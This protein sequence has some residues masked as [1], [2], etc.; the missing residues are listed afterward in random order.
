MSSDDPLPAFLR[1][2]EESESDFQAP[3]SVISPHAW[4]TD[5]AMGGTQRTDL[6]VPTGHRLAEVVPVHLQAIDTMVVMSAPLF[7]TGDLPRRRSTQLDEFAM[8]LNSNLVGGSVCRQNEV[9]MLKREEYIADAAAAADIELRLKNFTELHEATME[10]LELWSRAH[11]LEGAI[12][13]QPIHTGIENAETAE[14]PMMGIVW[15]K[16]RAKRVSSSGSPRDRT[17]PS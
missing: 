5:L 10:R 9:V 4:I 17:V 14:K 8:E 7:D 1:L 15:P 2:H 13:R 12:A 11:G 6:V 3:S 16:D